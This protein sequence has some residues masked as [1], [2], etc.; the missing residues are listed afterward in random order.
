M[1]PSTQGRSDGAVNS[2]KVVSVGVFQCNKCPEEFTNKGELNKHITI[3]HDK[4][5]AAPTKLVFDHATTAASA[6]DASENNEDRELELLSFPAD[7]ELEKDMVALGNMVTVDKIVDAFVETAYHEMNP[8]VKVNIP[9]CHE[10]TLKDEVIDNKEMLLNEKDDKIIQ[11]NAT[12]AGM[13]ITAKKS[14]TEITE[15]GKKIKLTESLKKTISEKNK[16]I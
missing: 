5:Q 10:C 2:L 9:P 6:N 12:I 16:E 8:S 13:T 7:I 4:A 14:A 15:M 1:Q 3:K 11:K